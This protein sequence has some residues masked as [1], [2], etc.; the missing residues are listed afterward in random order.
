MRRESRRRRRGV[1]EREGVLVHACT[2]VLPSPSANK[3]DKTITSSN[4]SNAQ[5]TPTS[6][7]ELIL[8]IMPV[9]SDPD[10]LT[11]KM[12]LDEKLR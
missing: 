11:S 2:R 6:N 3:H 10:P 1:R 8:L 5:G 12:M 9:S 4:C 7:T